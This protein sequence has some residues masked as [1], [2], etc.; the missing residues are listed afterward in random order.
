MVS[1]SA[2]RLAGLLDGVDVAA[3]PSPPR[4]A[5]PGAAEEHVPV[6]V[7]LDRAFAEFDQ[8]DAILL[9]AQVYGGLRQRDRIDHAQISPLAATNTG[10]DPHGRLAGATLGHF[11]GFLDRGW[12]RNDLMWGRLDGAEVLMRALLE[13]DRDQR[14]PEQLR[15]QLVDEVQRRIVAEERPDLAGGDW[16]A[17]LAQDARGDRSE[18]MGAG[19]LS[20][21]SLRAAAVVRRM[22]RTAAADG[23]HAGLLAASRAWLLR[24]LANGLGFV[25]ALVYLP[26]TL[27][28]ATGRWALRV[29]TG[30]ALAASLWGLVTLLLCAVQVL[31]FADVGAPAL[32][33]VAVYPAFLL[34]A[35]F[36]GGPLRKGWRRL[37]RLGGT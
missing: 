7:A 31:S 23:R 30:I 17:N 9:A 14:P 37:K 2:Q 29:A 27:F 13:G 34:A 32:V 22:L 35:W 16:K 6:D 36:L 19:R 3:A 12:R 1:G 26:L 24:V 20:A 28:F 10:V 25:L 4:H 8:R 18:Q 33:G 11:G 21:L 15:R 5:Q